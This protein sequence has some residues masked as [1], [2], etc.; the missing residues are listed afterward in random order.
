M[1][2]RGRLRVAAIIQSDE[3]CCDHPAGVV[4][5][6]LGAAKSYAL[7]VTVCVRALNISKT[8]MATNKIA[9]LSDSDP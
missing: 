8:P 4:C 9:A 2:F 5:L 1:I 7:S 3:R 6:T